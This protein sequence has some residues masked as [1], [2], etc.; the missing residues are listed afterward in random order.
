MDFEEKLIQALPQLRAFALSRL[1]NR[2]D[3][4]DL[5]SRA[6]TKILERRSDVDQVANLK[7]Y[8]ITIVRNL[9]IDDFRTAA[10]RKT[11]NV[12]E[13]IEV[14][15]PDDTELTVIAR[16][17]KQLIKSLPEQ[18]RDLLRLLGAGWKYDEIAK[19][20][21]LATNTVGTRALRC[22]KELK[23]LMEGNPA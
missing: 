19:N 6:V 21:N 22:R 5:V 15:A 20:L 10:R 7:A 11:D 16:Q 9:I 13:E 12:L 8:A 3:A 2:A 17:V 23:S 18:C 1:H 4:D 14:A